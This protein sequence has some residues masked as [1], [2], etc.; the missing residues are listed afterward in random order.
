MASP[1]SRISTAASTSLRRRASGPTSWPG[2]P[3]IADLDPRGLQEI[4]TDGR[5]FLSYYKQKSIKSISSCSRDIFHFLVT[6]QGLPLRAMSH[7][8]SP[9]DQF[10]HPELWKR[11][12]VGHIEDAFLDLLVNRGSRADERL[13]GIIRSLSGQWTIKKRRLGRRSRCFPPPQRSGPSLQ[14]L[15]WRSAHFPWQSARL[16]RCWRLFYGQDRTCSQ[17]AWS[18]C[19]HLHVAEHLPASS[20]DG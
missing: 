20:Q 15:P 6:F 14:R 2:Y 12:L 13:Q 4:N 8:I 18:S 7:T 9:F 19:L 10:W 11:Y 16:P 3:S 1:S 17:S 5:P